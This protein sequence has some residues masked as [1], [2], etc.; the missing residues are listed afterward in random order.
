MD[1]SEAPVDVYVD[2]DPDRPSGYDPATGEPKKLADHP[3]LLRDMPE[4]QWMSVPGAGG[5]GGSSFSLWYPGGGPGSPYRRI[6]TTFLFMLDQFRGNAPTGGLVDE[7]DEFNNGVSV[8]IDRFDE[9][10]GASGTFL[11]GCWYS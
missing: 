4:Q 3:L 1:V 6:P 2:F 8:T 5:F 9:I 10:N 7:S 11:I